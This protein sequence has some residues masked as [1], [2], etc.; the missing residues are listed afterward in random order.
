MTSK[1]RRERDRE[2]VR[3]L[4]LQAAT[5]L[6]GE[7]GIE[8]VSIRKIA[9]RIEYSPATIY[10][11]FADKD[12]IIDNL[13]RRGYQKIV[14][15]LRSAQVP[16]ADPQQ[17]L[18]EVARSYIKVVLA[19]REEYKSFL[20]STSPAI[21]EQTSV[22][23]PGASLKRP[24]VAMACQDIKALYGDAEVT[25]QHVE[26]TAQVLWAAAFGLALRMVIEE[27][28]P[29]QAERLIERHVEFIAAALPRP[30]H[31]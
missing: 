20:L 12:E 18:R 26:L 11:Y 1:D 2:R 19:N 14:G 25:D 7:E 24:T 3:E 30:Q 5:E 17:R 27:T 8:N 13:L 28:P 21:L 15:A 22:L 9:A 29:D 10:H 23:F 6:A 16:G 4:I 31:V